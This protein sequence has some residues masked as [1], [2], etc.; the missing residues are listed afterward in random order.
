MII[1]YK[2]IRPQELADSDCLLLTLLI[3]ILLFVCMSKYSSS[4]YQKRGD[5]KSR[6]GHSGH[7]RS[8]SSDESSDEYSRRRSENSREK[9]SHS[10]IHHSFK[11]HS[12]KNTMVKKVELLKNKIKSDLKIAENYM[13]TNANMEKEVKNM[14][15][16]GDRWKEISEIEKSG[17]AP[18]AFRSSDKKKNERKVSVQEEERKTFDTLENTSDYFEG[19]LT[20]PAVK[21]PEVLYTDAN[22]KFSIWLKRQVKCILEVFVRICILKNV[23]FIYSVMKLN[24]STLSQEPTLYTVI[25]G[26]AAGACSSVLF[27]PLDVIKTRFQN[28]SPALRHASVYEISL[29]TFKGEGIRG[30]WKGTWPTLCRMVPGVGFYFFQVQLIDN[31]LSAS[32]QPNLRH[33]L[34]GFIARAL[35][36]VVFMPLTIVKTRYESFHYSY[37]SIAQAIRLI[38]RKR[39]IRGLTAGIIP[40]ILRDAPYSG[41]YLLFYRFQMRFLEQ[42]LDTRLT[43]MQRF[44]CGFL[45]GGVAC[46][47]TQPFDTVRSR[48][49][50]FSTAEN[51]SLLVARQLLT[52]GGFLALFR[53]Y[54]LRMARKSLMSALNWTL[55]DLSYCNKY[56]FPIIPSGL[57]QVTIAEKG[58]KMNVLDVKVLNISS[59]Y[60]FEF[61]SS[62]DSG[63]VE[64]LFINCPI[65][66]ELKNYPMMNM[67]ACVWVCSI[68]L[69]DT[70]HAVKLNCSC[71]Q[72]G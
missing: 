56:L 23:I 60:I 1:Q 68:W 20:V 2:K 45:A 31:F 58:V 16:E 70:S 42:K 64:I 51:S 28:P 55:F 47:L 61:Y 40:T 72:G 41:L 50:L 57:L 22:E 17:F 24:A 11:R 33:L 18:Q 13:K 65:Q 25:F 67:L 5:W 44:G 36:T 53:G 63:E 52:K 9:S 14:L 32:I 8:Q 19:E 66:W 34:V 59:E 29:H 62:S 21:I 48:M 30:F 38:I 35:T 46:L 43:D 7:R 37:H 39:H 12:S 4:H 54:T 49:Q 15:T 26:L 69:C 10:K 6:H 71:G 27:Q 3:S